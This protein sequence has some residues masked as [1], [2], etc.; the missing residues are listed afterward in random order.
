MKPSIVSCPLCN[1]STY[2]LDAFE[3]HLFDSHSTTS[4]AL[5]DLQHPSEKHCRCGCGRATKW[6]NYRVGYSRFVVGHNGSIYSSY[7]TEAA[8]SISEKR[9][10]SL[11]GKH[12][13]CKG[14]TKENNEAVARR[15]EATSIGRREALNS[16]TIKIWSKGLTKES[17]E[18]IANFA[19]NLK[20][21][22]ANGIYV[23]WAKG[24][25]KYTDE[26]VAD[27]ASNV[28][29][30]HSKKEVREHL[31][32]LKRLSTDEVQ[33]RVL[34][35][36]Y[37]IIDGL[38]NY[39]SATDQVL[40][41]RCKECGTEKYESLRHIEL[42]RCIK[43]HPGGSRAQEEI[44]SFIESLGFQITRNDR[45]V[46]QN[47]LELD[48][49]VPSKKFAIEYNGLYWH[50]ETNKS[51]TYHEH[52]SV[53]CKELGIDLFHIYEDEW[54]DKREIIKSM[55]KHR[56]GLTEKR[57][58]A[59]LLQVVQ[60]KPNDQRTSKFMSMNHLEGN[61]WCNTVFCLFDIDVPIAMMS[62]RKTSNRCFD[63]ATYDIVRFATMLN[64]HV[65]GGFSRLLKH[66]KSWCSDNNIST[67]IMQANIRYGNNKLEK[68]GT[69]HHTV[70]PTFWWTDNDNRYN[71]NKCRENLSLD[72]SKNTTIINQKFYKIW[73]CHSDVY[74]L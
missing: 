26:R 65:V 59:S 31:D 64:S 2:K 33:R 72:V 3:R 20:D 35:N 42:G 15:A 52:K 40:L 5:Y 13:W 1:Y 37:E 38:E 49:Y 34:E 32:S 67:T 17:D 29:F 47:R 11:K 68:F 51:K 71:K 46:M 36:K 62:L 10:A 54:R 18:R 39:T 25:T 28:S 19:N 14:L 66:A 45:E 41:I 9:K 21:G 24:K 61:T 60:L 69:L 4:R 7:D 8:K 16:G 43:C 22:Y 48:I 6:N 57:Y 44:A 56:L 53:V 73:G 63:D 55:I 70:P 74:V 30:T 58:F 12:S 50:N 27:M 23:P